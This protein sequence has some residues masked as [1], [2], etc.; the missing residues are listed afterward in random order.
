M[1]D[2]IKTEVLKI[3][4]RLFVVR[5][6][7]TL[8]GYIGITIWLNAIRATAPI[9]LIWVLII[10]QLVLYILIF[11]ISYRRSEKLGLKY[12]FVIFIILS[13]LGRVE[14]W[15]LIIIPMLVITMLIY[16]ARDN[17]ILNKKNK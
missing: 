13:V 15:E 16:S 5:I 8:M 11:F 7:G 1:N 3:K 4:K 10:I 9:W 14:N 12:A 6:F 2:F 17:N